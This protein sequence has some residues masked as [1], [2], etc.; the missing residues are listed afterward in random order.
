MR[1]WEHREEGLLTVAQIGNPVAGLEGVGDQVSV[2]QADA[3]GLVGGTTGI[4]DGSQ[5]LARD[6]DVG[7]RPGR[8]HHQLTHQMPPV[9]F[10][11][12]LLFAKSSRLPA[13]QELFVDLG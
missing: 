1:Q 2:G 12:L 9:A 13:G 5:V 10:V 6:L 11:G 8:V 4:E 7:R 3:L